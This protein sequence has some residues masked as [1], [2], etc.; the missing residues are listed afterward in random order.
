M[1]IWTQQDCCSYRETESLLNKYA[2]LRSFCKV[3]NML[4]A[5]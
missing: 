5:A 3:A 2:R 4:I 1:V